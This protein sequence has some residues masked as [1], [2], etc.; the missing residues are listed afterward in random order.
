MTVFMLLEFEEI[1]TR[2]VKAVLV[3]N[4]EGLVTWLPLSKIN[5][6][7]KHK[8]E[9]PEWLYDR[10]EWNVNTRDMNYTMSENDS[11]EL[12]ERLNELDQDGELDHPVPDDYDPDY[13]SDF[14]DPSDIP[15]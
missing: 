6:H 13:V 5:L 8:A 9:I 15:Y 11:K 14:C 12:K 7:G 2:T 10:L 1:V 4:D 3:S